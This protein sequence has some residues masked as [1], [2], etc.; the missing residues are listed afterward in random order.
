VQIKAA[1]IVFGEIPIIA[2]QS[3]AWRMPRRDGFMPL[4]ET[5]S[6]AACGIG[7]GVT[8]G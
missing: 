4:G 5:N 8:R 7:E 1:L 6:A 3:V 2:A